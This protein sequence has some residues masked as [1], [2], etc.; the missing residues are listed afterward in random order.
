MKNSIREELGCYIQERIGEMI[1]YKELPPDTSDLHF[2]L[3]NQDHYI[4]GYYQCEQWLKTHGLSAWEAMGICQEYEIEHFGEASDKYNNSETVVNMLAY[5]YG[6][7]LL[8]E[9]ELESK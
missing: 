8:Y 2:D 7:E 5:I 3:F 9:L 1:M 6:E 4:I